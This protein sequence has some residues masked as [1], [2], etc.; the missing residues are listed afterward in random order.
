[1]DFAAIEAAGLEDWLDGIETEL[2]AKTYQP[3]PVRRVMIPKPGGG[4][5]PL[6]IP[7]RCA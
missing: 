2:R 3:Q 7:T 4:E 6:G 5:R 1:V